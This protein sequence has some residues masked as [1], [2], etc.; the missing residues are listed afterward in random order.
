MKKNLGWKLCT[1]I[2]FGALMGVPAHDQRDYD[3]AK[4]YNIKLNRSLKS[5]EKVDISKEA[6]VKKGVIIN[7]DF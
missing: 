3:F 7:S 6:F 5:D 1:S 4:K 2:W